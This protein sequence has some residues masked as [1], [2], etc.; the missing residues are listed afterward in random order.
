MGPCKQ[1]GFFWGQFWP[2]YYPID[3]PCLSAMYY[4]TS[5]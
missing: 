5:C 2:L 1:V 3:P 4:Y